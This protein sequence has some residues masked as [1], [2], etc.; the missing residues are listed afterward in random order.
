MRNFR[1]TET[2]GKIENAWSVSFDTAMGAPNQTVFKTLTDWSQ[3]ADE[4]IKYYSGAAIYRKLFDLP[5]GANGKL[6]LNLGKVK[7]IAR[8]RLNGKDLGVVWTNPWR[9]NITN[10]VQSVNNQL[11]IEVVNLWANRLIGDEHLPADGIDDNDGQWPQWLLDGTPRTS[12]RHTFATFRHYSKRSP[13]M[14]SGLLGPVTIE[15][16]R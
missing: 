3:N 12:G 16:E 13:L 15:A 1:R 10:A 14:E 8:V 6:Y 7:N 5:K 11:E 2:L 4:G 9:V